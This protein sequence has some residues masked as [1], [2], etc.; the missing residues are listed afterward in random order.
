MVAA[1]AAVT[2]MAM[3]IIMARAVVQTRTT[4]VKVPL[5]R[6]IIKKNG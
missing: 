5:L 3:E 2:G 6:T 1:I 4:T